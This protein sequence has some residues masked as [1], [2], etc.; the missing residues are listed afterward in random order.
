MAEK[1]KATGLSDNL[2]TRGANKVDAEKESAGYLKAVPS[3]PGGMPR[4]SFIVIQ[5]IKLPC[6]F[7]ALIQGLARYSKTHC[8]DGLIPLS[9]THGF[10][11]E[12]RYRLFQ[13]GKMLGKGQANPFRN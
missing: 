13:G 3:N 2:R 11:N 4:S 10:V 6:L 1:Q 8:S 9:P 5:L 7:K 12:K